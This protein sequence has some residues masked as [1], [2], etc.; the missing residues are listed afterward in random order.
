MKFFKTGQGLL[1]INDSMYFKKI[2]I[3]NGSCELH[4]G[5]V[6]EIGAPTI[7]IKDITNNKNLEIEEILEK[8]KQFL[9]IVEVDS[10]Y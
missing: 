1:P 9:T 2:N 6:T 4:I 10:I 3:P 8:H 7:L 5:Y